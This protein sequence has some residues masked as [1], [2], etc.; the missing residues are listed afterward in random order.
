MKRKPKIAVIGAKGFPAWGGAARSNEAIF[1]RVID[2]FDITVYAISSHAT[3]GNYQGIKQIIFK[4]SRNKKFSVLFYH[5]KSIFNLLTKGNFDL[6]HI[7]H[8]SIGI[9]VPLIRLKYPVL[10]NIHGMP[11]KWIDDKWSALEKC[12]IIIA[13]NIGFRYANR[14][15]TVQKGSTKKIEEV[16]KNPVIFIPNG[17]DNNFELID[18]ESFSNKEFNITFAAAR[19]IY[20]KGLHLLLD[21]LNHINY[22]GKVQIIG[23]INQV[24]SYKEKIFKSSLTLE[25]EFAGLIHK[26]DNLFKRIAQS[27]L[28]VFPSYTEGM[29]NMLLEVASLKI[30][31]IASNIPQN[32][33]VFSDSEILFFKSGDFIDLQNKIN[34]ALNNQ[35]KMIENAKLAYEKVMHHHNWDK[36]ALQYTD[37]YNE[38]ICK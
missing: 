32:T 25:C 12:Y 36:I 17:V 35:L 15:V 31:I 2:K 13:Q 11:T 21:A 10:L 34:W 26:K 3:E 28:F 1:T 8:R 24:D 33:E 4:A 9:F 37:V 20:L 6:V 22:D 18:S 14:I 38:M 19:I 16:H 5:I 30:P 27:E 23:D 7:N 29:S